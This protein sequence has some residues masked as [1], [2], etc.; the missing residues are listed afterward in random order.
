MRRPTLDAVP[1]NGLQKTLKKGGWPD[2]RGSQQQLSF[3]GWIGSVG[4]EKTGTKLPLTTYGLL[5]EATEDTEGF[6]IFSLS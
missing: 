4:Q 1:D 5:M 2:E 3:H 6:V